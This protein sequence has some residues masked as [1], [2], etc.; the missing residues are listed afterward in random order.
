MHSELGGEEE[1]DSQS[2]ELD[3]IV[4]NGQYSSFPRGWTKTNDSSHAILSGKS[5]PPVSMEVPPTSSHVLTVGCPQHFL[6][7]LSDANPHF[8]RP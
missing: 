3:R 6:C 7:L 2:K 4:I 1:R 5:K 8:G